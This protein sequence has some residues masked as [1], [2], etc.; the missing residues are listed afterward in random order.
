MLRDEDV[1][2]RSVFKGAQLFQ[3]LCDFQ[4]TRLPLN[5]LLEKIPAE[6]V[7]PHV[8]PALH[9]QMMAAGIGNP[10]AGK[11]ERAAI[12][13]EDTFYNVR[14]V[15][16][17]LILD[18][19]YRGDHSDRGVRFHFFREFVHEAGRNERLVPLHIDDVS[20]PGQRS[21][22]FGDAVGT[23]LVIRRSH[24]NVRTKTARRR[25]DPAVVRRHQNPVH[26]AAPPAALPHMLNEGFPGD[27]MQGLPGKTG[28]GEAGGNNDSTG[29][30]SILGDAGPGFKLLGALSRND[31]DY[32]LIFCRAS[33]AAG[34]YP[35]KPM[36]DDDDATLLHAWTERR[37]EEA[38]RQ[39]VERYAGLVYGT[40]RRRCGCGELAAEAAQDVFVKLAQRAGSLRRT[41]ALA[42]WLHTAAVRA[43]TDRMRKES[44]YRNYMKRFLEEST[45]LAEEGAH[46]EQTWKE[47]LPHLDEAI[48]RLSEPERGILL[49]RYSQGESVAAAGKRFGL[50]AAAAQKRGERALEKLAGFLKRRGVTL[51]ATLLGSGLS[52]QMA[53]AVPVAMQGKWCAAALSAGNGGALSGWLSF[54]N[55]RAVSV[56]AALAGVTVPI[57]LQLSANAKARNAVATD[58]TGSAVFKFT[59][60]SVSSATGMRPVMNG[61]DLNVLAREIHAFPPKQG[62]LQKELE[63]RAVMQTLDAGQCAVVAKILTESPS[64]RELSA[65]ASDLYSRWEEMD[66]EAA[67]AGAQEMK[68]TWDRIAETAVLTAWAE[69]DPQEMLARF[70]SQSGKVDAG[71]LAGK[72]CLQA[73]RT[74][75]ERDPASAMQA[76]MALP[77]MSYASGSPMVQAVL[78]GWA[79]TDVE[80]A[81]K[82]FES[83]AAPGEKESYFKE[84][85]YQKFVRDLRILHP[86][87]AWNSLQRWPDRELADREAGDTLTEWA[88][89]DPFA[90]AS[91]WADAPAAWKTKVYAEKLGAGIGYAD[92]SLKETIAGGIAD[93]RLK[94]AFV[95]A[96][97]KRAELTREIRPE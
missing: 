2:R 70:A 93:G 87:K 4:W 42:G 59:P 72:A 79:Y 18:G 17:Q 5:E 80:A 94:E 52:A 91:A 1:D 48:R 84:A 14:I 40:A 64:F 86:D 20:H 83:K 27:D 23:A 58:G 63:L 44:K 78:S 69:K 28:G 26:I 88:A 92:P 36:L 38:F 53:E 50:S 85:H 90:A 6:T 51:S 60:S 82:W 74:W 71:T 16:Q 76:A 3:R 25:R 61:L 12:A 62:R 77:T 7:D 35:Q 8:P 11:I 81:V 45:V 39:L 15:E 9:I 89:K 24:T 55:T 56:V 37:S 73:L 57:G 19:M 32:L 75:A 49:A 22:G 34:V 10:A 96:V 43:A 97:E 13:G 47:A 30:G 54:L 66:R 67:L 33:D 31:T 21:C 41:E 68:G 65:I 46:D 95:K 29:H